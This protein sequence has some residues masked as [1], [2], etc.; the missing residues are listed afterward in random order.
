MRLEL[1]DGDDAFLTSISFFNSLLHYRAD[2][3]AWALFKKILFVTLVKDTKEE[4]FSRRMTT[5]MEFC[6]RREKLSSTP[7]IIRKSGDL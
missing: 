1:K 5:T 6:S 4:F 3:F 7:N 2:I